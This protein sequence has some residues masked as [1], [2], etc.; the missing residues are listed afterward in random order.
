MKKTLQA[1]SK[2]F[3]AREE[4][5]SVFANA[6]PMH[7]YGYYDCT[8]AKADLLLGGPQELH[9]ASKHL[10][11]AVFGGLLHQVEKVVLFSQQ[12]TDRSEP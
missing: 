1:L 10:V 11:L 7:V 5:L 3:D 8:K 2:H 4:T 9:S 12:R 6:T